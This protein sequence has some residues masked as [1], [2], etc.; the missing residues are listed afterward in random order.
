MNLQGKAALVTGA[1]RGVG[2]ATALRLARAGCAV[3][4]NYHKSR[5]EAERVAAE[6]RAADGRAEVCQ[7]NVADDAA[8]RAAVEAT[9][10]AF[11]RLDIL[12]NNAGVT[13]FI[14]FGDLAAVTDADWE[15]IFSTNVKGVFQCVRAARPHLEAARGVVVNVASVA[16]MNGTGSSI[17]YCASK[18]AVLSL[19][20]SLARTLAPHVR[21]HAVSPGFIAGD[22][23]RAGLGAD[24][25]RV[26]AGRIAATPLGRVAEPDDVAAAIMSLITGSEFTTGQNLVVD[27]GMNLGTK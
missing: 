25:E 4:V 21:V 22:W 20:L 19:T 13:R 12:V 24:Y 1:G 8:C 6:I 14:P 23:T 26:K 18:A 9:V 10:R 3:M 27:G 16:G 2:R 17:P 7:G 5:I 15:L 11:G